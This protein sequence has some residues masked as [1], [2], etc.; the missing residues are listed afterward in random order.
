MKRFDF[1]DTAILALI[2][3]LLGV[4]FAEFISIEARQFHGNS[5]KIVHECEK[6][7][8]RNQ[9]CKAII[10]AVIIDEIED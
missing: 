5:I 7:I 9:H 3:F 1:I 6:T 4:F 10:T 8:P 2:M